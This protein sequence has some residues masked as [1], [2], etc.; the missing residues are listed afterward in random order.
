MGE[1]LIGGIIL[2]C[3]QSFIYDIS[4]GACKGMVKKYK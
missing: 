2:S 3:V 4:T 1:S